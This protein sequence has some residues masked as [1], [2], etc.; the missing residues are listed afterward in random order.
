MTNEMGLSTAQVKELQRQ[1]LINRLE[2]NQEKSTKEIVREHTL[3]FFNLIFVVLAILLIIVGRFNDMAFL[4]I[5]IINSAIGIIQELRSRKE[6]SKLKV[7]TQGKITAIRDGKPV[8][9]PVVE[10]VK[11]DI[12]ELSA[13][14]QIPADGVVCE[15][16]IQVNESL[17]TGEADLITKTEGSKIMSGSFVVSGKCRARMLHVGKES[18]AAKLT[19]KAK[20]SRNLKKTGMMKSLDRLI[21]VVGFALIPIGIALF[22]NGYV[23]NG[24]DFSDTIPNVVAALIGMIP[25][26]LY[27]LTSM[28]L[29]VS[30]MRLSKDKVLYTIC[31]QLKHWRG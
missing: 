26:G 15:G 13:G 25:E 21:K 24:N 19:N 7:L 27:L 18:Y 14:N 3:T 6:L 5:A 4:V 30:V 31:P 16:K 17:L 28:A 10:I 9:I 23:V 22:Y 29:A 12:I 8:K 11:G 1:G 20:E 2:D